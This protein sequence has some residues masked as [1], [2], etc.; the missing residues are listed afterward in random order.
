VEESFKYPFT[1]TS[2]ATGMALMS[3]V[4]LIIRHGADGVVDH[5]DFKTGSYGGDAWQNFIARLTVAHGREVRGDQLRTVNILTKSLEYKVIPLDP[6]EK[7]HTWETIKQAIRELAEDSAWHA[8][9]DPWSCRFC[10]FR[11]ACSWA[12]PLPDDHDC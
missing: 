11:P 8:R 4:D 7:H 3:R 6:S 9:P 10:D 1:L 12:A 5:I 2:L